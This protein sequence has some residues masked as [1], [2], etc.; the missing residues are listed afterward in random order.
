VRIVLDT[1]VIISAILFGGVPKEILT[2]TLKL[3]NAFTMCLSEAI[4][5]ELIRVLKGTKFR[6]PSEITAEIHSQLIR[7]A[8]IVNPP[9]HLSVIKKDPD[10]N[11]VLEAATT[12]LAH[13]IVTGDKHL[14]D[15][16]EY[17]GIEIIK[18]RIFKDKYL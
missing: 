9:E 7:K 16:K 10:D 15:L 8:F 11:R 13:V 2:S 3:D 4:I 18:P 5:R 17:E 12:T 6:F 1:N 14:L